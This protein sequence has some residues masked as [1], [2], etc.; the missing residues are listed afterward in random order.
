MNR[1]RLQRGNECERRILGKAESENG[2][3]GEAPSKHVHWGRQRASMCGWGRG[4]ANGR[5]DRRQGSAIGPSMWGIE[6]L[7]ERK[8]E[9]EEGG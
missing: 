9:S 3:V 5:D 2:V 1:L 6:S 4:A 7:I 8:E